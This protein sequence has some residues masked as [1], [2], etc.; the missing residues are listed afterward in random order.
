MQDL[1][2]A[3]AA[4]RR[5]VWAYTDWE[6]LPE[7]RLAERRELAELQLAMRRGPEITKANPVNL[8]EAD[9]RA[10]EQLPGIGPALAARIIEQRERAPFQSKAELTKVPGIGPQ[11]PH[12]RLN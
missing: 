2:L 8:N 5:G 4:G 10:L 9:A 7:E 1:E 6:A 12:T 3:A 11:S